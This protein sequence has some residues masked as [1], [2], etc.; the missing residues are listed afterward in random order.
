MKAAQHFLTQP[1]KWHTALTTTVFFY[2]K[3]S[4]KAA[5]INQDGGIHLASEWETVKQASDMFQSD[6]NT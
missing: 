2:T 4:L 5:E 3:E 6:H 1:Q